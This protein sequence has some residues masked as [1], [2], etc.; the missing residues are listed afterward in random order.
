MHVSKHRR[1]MSALL[2]ALFGSSTTLAGAAARPDGVGGPND[3]EGFIPTGQFITATAAPGSTYQ[4]MATLLRKDGNADADDAVSSAL[5]PDGRTLL[6]LTSGFNVSFNYENGRPINFPVLDPRTGKAAPFVNPSTG[7][8]QTDYNQAE[9]V[10]VYDVTR[11]NA[12]V[13]QRIAIP[14]T[15]SGLAWDPRGGRFFVSGGVDDR[16]LVYKGSNGNAY[17]PDAPFVVLG[18]NTND[19]APL[20]NYDGGILKNTTAGKIAPSLVTG[21]VVSGLDVSK[22][23]KTLVAANFENASASVVDLTK[24]AV[25]NEV[26]FFVPGQ[27]TPVGEYPYGVAVRSDYQT[28]AFAEAYVSSQRDDQVI[29]MSKTAVRAVIHVPSGPNKMAL[30]GDQSRL[31]VA[32]GNDDS[33]AVIDTATDRVVRVISLA[34]PGDRL[35]GANPNAIAVGPYGRTI[36]VSLGGENAVAV[37]DVTSGRVTGRIPT[38]WLPT[39]V[40]LAADGT[41]MYVPNEKSNSGPNPGQT[42]YSWNTPYGISLNRTARNEYTWATE[43]AG[44][45]TIPMPDVNTVS[46]L[47]SVVDANNGFENRNASDPTMA[48]LRTKIKHVIYIV[49]ENRTYDQVLGDLHNGANGEPRLTFFTQPIA[50]N[51]HALADDYVTLDNFYDSSESS[52]VGWNWA[53]QG[54]TNDFTEKTQAVQYGNSNGLGLTYDWQGIV[55]HINLGLP[56]TGPPS[57]F[58]TRITGIL[59]PS[60]KSTILPGPKDPAASEGANDLNARALGGYVWESALRAGRS[61]RNYGWQ[62]DLTYYGTGTPFDPALVRH[63]F[64]NGKLQSAPS[65]PSI[66]PITDRYYRAFDMRYPDIFR[67]EEWRRE[68]AQF[69]KTGNMPNLMTMTIP[70]DHFGKFGSA[71]EGLGTPQL[72][73]SDH[74]YAV[75][76]LVETVSHSRFWGSTAIVMIEDDP[77][78]GQDHVEA[79]RSIAHVISPYTRRHFVDHTTYTTVSAL[80]TVEALLGIEP[81]GLNDANAPTMSDAFTTQQNMQPYVAVIPGALCA[82]P[83]ARDLVPACGSHGARL[84]RRVADLHDASWWAARTAGFD[85]RKPDRVNAELFDRIL[86][87]GL[88]GRG[89]LPSGNDVARAAEGPGDAD[90]I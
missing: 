60:G 82:P 65:T 87:N 19:S 1:T 77:Q 27:L 25:S 11:G 46:Y 44:L 67:I 34:R 63:P 58:S 50:P 56:P 86:A 5:S 52:G 41:R 31:Y 61:V 22:D 14:D 47:S 89:T 18:H 21:A 70:H 13:L 74:D 42:Y 30:S 6:V 59:D 81:L 28:G 33:V 53:M 45:D 84:T 72:Q 80:H 20:P 85:F 8:M 75:G 48:F 4:R 12:R 88:T 10:F 38:G 16:V 76:Q 79:H 23:G 73:M 2:L 39:S 78:N 26:R 15:Y 7:G 83:V 37:V 49:N 71:I 3:G 62:I 90:G 66:Q 55:A 54:H 69:E 57:I 36:Y 40:S 17:F 24:R 64:E 9:W 51:L 35:K 43:K 29:A 68:F 32:C